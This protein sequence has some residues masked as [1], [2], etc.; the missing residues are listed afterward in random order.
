MNN[1]SFI[2]VLCQSTIEI[3]FDTIKE[4]KE[5]MLQYIEPIQKQQICLDCFDKFMKPYKERSQ[6]INDKISKLDKMQNEIHKETCNAHFKEIIAIKPEELKEPL[7]EAEKTYNELKNEEKDLTEQL[8][9]LIL[10]LDELTKKE[11]ELVNKYKSTE[12]ETFK[13]NKEFYKAQSTLN[14]NQNI[15]SDMMNNENNIFDNLFQIS[16]NDKYGTIN[17]CRFLLQSNETLYDEISRGWGHIIFLTNILVDKLIK[18]SDSQYKYECEYLLY[19]F[20]HYSYIESKKDHKQYYL[21][22]LND[23]GI[24]QF[25]EGM[26]EYLQIIKFLYVIVTGIN[27]NYINE[28]FT[29]Y[30][31]GINSY[32]ITIYT[33]SQ[34]NVEDWNN[35]MKSLLIILKMYMNAV[36]KSE[37][38]KLNQIMNRSES[39]WNI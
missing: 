38:E 21:Y 1:Y 26:I 31:K 19:P 32:P 5:D 11:K 4:T 28:N 17:G 23:D 9:N 14:M 22:F 2:C 37:N 35:C 39:I 29:I 33:N 20:G 34:E 16:I 27:P 8:D 12:N 10:E 15:Q 7:E 13:A 3:N 25:N 36:L 18:L 24:P 30:D 6:K